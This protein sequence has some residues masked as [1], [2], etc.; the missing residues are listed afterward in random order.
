V[1]KRLEIAT[2][3][4]APRRAWHAAVAAFAAG[5]LDPGLL[6]T[7]ELDL[8][9]AGDAFELLTCRDPSVGKVLL[10]P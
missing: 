10:R 9:A 6:V 8:A 1:S 5:V 3:F 2:V 4:G 7:H